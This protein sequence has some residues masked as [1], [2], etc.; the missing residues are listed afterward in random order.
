MTNFEN[1]EI[2]KNYILIEKKNYKKVKK[3]PS[4]ESC[5]L[6][7]CNFHARHLVGFRSTAKIQQL[8]GYNRPPITS[9]M[10]RLAVNERVNKSSVEKKKLFLYIFIIFLNVLQ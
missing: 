2:V 6:A 7:F 8:D 4:K 9:Q 10:R 1:A 3:R 5:D